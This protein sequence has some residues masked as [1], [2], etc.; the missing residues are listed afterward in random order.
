[1]TNRDLFQPKLFATCL[2][3]DLDAFDLDRLKSLVSPK[4]RERS[5]KFLFK[6][7]KARCLT[8]ELLL[9]HALKNI[10][11][12]TPHVLD[13][14][15]NQYGKPSLANIDNIH[16]SISHSGKWVLVGIS[17]AAIGVDVE[18]IHTISDGL[19]Q[20]FFS[21]DECMLLEDCDGHDHML[22]MFYRIW[23]LKESYI[24]A[25]GKGMY[26]PLDAFSV[27]PSDTDTASLRLHDQSLPDMYLKEYSIGRG[28]K[29]A[30]AS[31]ID[32]FPAVVECADI[33]HVIQLTFSP[34]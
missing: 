12:K 28:Y 30:M 24:K 16:F 11:I 6:A 31:A 29:A 2:P 33:N 7:D 5:E 25:I 32:R 34:Y 21:P 3:D 13:F 18:R 26:C 1:M 22:D 14:T 10:D 27:L 17:S 9:R 4:R 15:F 8:G 23:V 19:A 20:R